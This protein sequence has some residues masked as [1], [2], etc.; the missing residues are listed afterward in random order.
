ARDIWS[1]PITGDRKPFPVVQTEFVEMSGQ[2]SPDGRWIAYESNESGEFEI[3]VTSFP[4]PGG[5][6]RISR[7]GGSVPRWRRDGKELYYMAKDR[8]LTATEV[9]Q[10]G[11]SI[12]A[13]GTRPLFDVPLL[14]RFIYFYDV[15]P[16]GRRFLVN[17]IEQS[18]PSPITLVINWTAELKR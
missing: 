4:G 8:K 1:L 9:R 13:G 7:S 16:D 12:E 2:F 10:A 15:S 17:P 11:S 3:Y 18:R 6:M 14:E 5:K